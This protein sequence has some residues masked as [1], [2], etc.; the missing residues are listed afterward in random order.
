MR[1]R[2][3]GALLPQEVRM[4][5]TRAASP[6]QHRP[7]LG[8]GEQGARV[9]SMVRGTARGPW[10]VTTELGGRVDCLVST[11]ILAGIGTR[12]NMI[13]RPRY[14][15]KSGSL[16]S[17]PDQ[18]YWAQRE[19]EL[20]I[21]A[22]EPDPRNLYM[23]FDEIGDERLAGT[24]EVFALSGCAFLGRHYTSE[25]IAEWRQI[26]SKIFKV[27][28]NRPFHARRHLNKLRHSQK[29]L[30]LDLL[31]RME[32]RFF[33]SLTTTQA[34]HVD[35]DNALQAVIEMCSGTYQLFLQDIY[36]VE[37]VFEHSFR[38]AP[39]LMGM[40]LPPHPKEGH[41]PNLWFIDKKLCEP[42]AEIADLVN[43]VVLQMI[44]SPE[45][46]K[47]YKHADIYSN[48]FATGRGI[49][50]KALFISP[51]IEIKMEQPRSTGG[52]T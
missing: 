41:S 47:P 10:S 12:K 51:T 38:L 26:K 30:V 27:E 44:G 43:Y 36:A 11:C 4:R 39:Q 45:I 21:E 42:A 37:W 18:S 9:R 13:A 1:P 23:F 40:K 16:I 49:I 3:S 24:S 25:L 28:I 31:D 2:A 8:H 34:I 32:M 29:V 6:A 20:R 35:P 46:R 5:I 17:V 33:S 22:F 48:L 50:Q 19:Q 7:F 52:H 14:S 15:Q